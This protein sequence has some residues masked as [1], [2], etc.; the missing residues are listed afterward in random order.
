MT[1]LAAARANYERLDRQAAAMGWAP[2]DAKS[3]MRALLSTAEAVVA[4]EQLKEDEAAATKR[5]RYHD[6]APY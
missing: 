3:I 1:P 4:R 6:R 2:A 5:E